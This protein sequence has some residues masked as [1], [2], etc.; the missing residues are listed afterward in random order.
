VK[1]LLTLLLSSLIVLGKAA[2]ASYEVL[3]LPQGRVP[4]IDGSLKEWTNKYFIDSLDSDNNVIY[5]DSQEPWTRDDL[6]MGFY[7]AWDENKLYFGIKIIYDDVLITSGEDIYRIDNIKVNPGGQAMAFYI[8]IDGT[9]KLNPSSPYTLETNLWAAMQPNGND[10]FP[11]Y[12]FAID[13]SLMDPFMMSMFQFAIG[14][15]DN[16]DMIYSDATYIVVGA[17]FTGAKSDGCGCAWDNPLYYPTFTLV[18]KTGPPLNSSFRNNALVYGRNL[19]I[20]AYPNPFNLS[21]TLF[22]TIEDHGLLRIFDL[23]GQLLRHFFL[24][25]K[26]GSIV[27]DGSMHNGSKA[28]PGTYVAQLRSRKQIQT[29]KLI[30]GR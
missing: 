5:R 19:E 26:T 13:K 15:E 11:T 14:S 28:V 4:V 10:T 24:D 1:A 20:N 17:E 23:K 12:E 29:L 27:W 25:G 22:Y 9:V 3:K 6:Q 8:G 2:P 16:D 21:T 7:A 30:I 18:S